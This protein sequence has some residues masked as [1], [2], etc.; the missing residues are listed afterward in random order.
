MKNEKSVRRKVFDAVSDVKLYWK[1][2]KKGQDL[3]YREIANYSI[4][5]F[6]KEFVRPL[7]GCFGL[8]ANTFLFFVVGLTLMEMYIISQVIA[9][10]A[11]VFPFIRAKIVDNTR[12]RYGRFRPYLAFSGFGLVALTILFISLPYDDMTRTTVI[13]VV[14]LLVLVSQFFQPFYD[15]SYDELRTVMTP[16][17]NERAKLISISSLVYSLAITVHSS[18]FPALSGLFATENRIGLANINYYRAILIPSALIGL[19]ICLFAAFGTKERIVAAKKYSPKVSVMQGVLQIFKNKYWWMNRSVEV[20]SFA[21]GFFSLVFFWTFFYRLENAALYG[22]LTLVIG[23]SGLIAMV[24]APFLI[25]KIGSIRARYLRT[26][27]CFVSILL[28]W[29]TMN[30]VFLMSVFFYVWT[31]SMDLGIV[32]DPVIHS[33][34][35]DYQ[36]YITGKRMDFTFGAANNFF[37]PVLMLTAFVQPFLFQA[38]GVT[39]NNNILFDPALQG[40]FWNVLF[41]VSLIGTVVAFIP[42]LFYNLTDSKQRGMVSVLR[43]R[44]LF[45]DM[46]DGKLSDTQVRDVVNEVRKSQEIAKEEK[47]DLQPF[48]KAFWDKLKKFKPKQAK[49]AYSEYVKTRNENENI[50]GANILI[51]EMEK[52]STPLFQ[53]K[54]SLAEQLV[55]LSFG[56]KT[57]AFFRQAEELPEGEQR[58]YAQKFAKKAQKMTEKIAKNYPFG[59][60]GEYDMSAM[61]QALSMPNDTK[62]QQKSRTAAIKA[63]E[64]KVNKYNKTVHAYIEAKELLTQRSYFG[65]YDE[66]EAMYDDAVERI[67][68]A[69]K[70][71]VEL[72]GAQI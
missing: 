19:V 71:A 44:A 49:R 16:N 18:V 11:F 42:F 36:Q 62:E 66:I 10:V 29:M 31:L 33:N 52:F 55:A 53:L 70:L 72:K 28:M 3:S 22:L 14:G 38:F 26:A 34:V 59:L 12:T 41:L 9:V 5:G 48:K 6:G 35:K 64:K 68:E 30:N 2:P 65:R 7:L 45:Q 60:E 13:L 46:A 4:G 23:T 8:G 37:I 27:V 61:E 43:Y 39:N 51:S 21:K 57:D 20:L 17:T 25:K 63:E 54:T 69:E 56:E 47:T 67:K 40:G 1:K 50:E 24:F 15:D 32:L 58:R